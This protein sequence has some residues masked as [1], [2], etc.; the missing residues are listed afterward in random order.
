MKLSIII[1]IFNE[2]PTIREVLTWVDATEFP[3]AEK[4][5]ILV[6]DFSTDGTREILKEYEG[7]YRVEYHERNYG[8]GH[9]VRTGI[10]LATGDYITIQDADL[11]YNP[12]DLIPM[13]EKMVAE[14]LTVIYGSREAG[15]N[16]NRPSGVLFYF[17][18]VAVTIAMNILYGQKLT[19]GMTCYKMYKA[20]FLKSLPLKSERFEFE[21]EVMALTAKR[22]IKIPE[23]PI[24]YK[25]RGVDE[26][27]KINWKDAVRCFWI[28]F[29]YR[30]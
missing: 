23:Y 18:G 3:G 8:K 13:F 20:D 24:T 11:E 21:P 25:P 9:A 5:I 15:A 12:A 29:K 22:G 1:P 2:A 17:G 6:D 14:N 10:A 16:R 30:F 19:D 4:E 26:G 27:K 7:K 28:L